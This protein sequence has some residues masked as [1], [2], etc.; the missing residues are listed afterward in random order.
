ML[1]QDEFDCIDN[2]LD[3]NFQWQNMTKKLFDSLIL[4]TLP[5]CEHLPRSKTYLA[6][7]VEAI[8]V[9]VHKRGSTAIALWQSREVIGVF[10]GTVLAASLGMG[11]VATVN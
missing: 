7:T 3:A 11:F 8:A 9:K 2:Q 1:K 4:A 6:W 5:D 10:G